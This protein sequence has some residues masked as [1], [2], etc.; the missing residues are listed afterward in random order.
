MINPKLSE[1]QIE[2]GVTQGIGYSLYE[3]YYFDDKG[4]LINDSF[5]DYKLPTSMDAPE[6]I[7]AF[8]ESFEVKGPFGAKGI[9]EPTIVPTA[10]AIANAIYDAIGIRLTQMPF[11]AQKVKEALK[12]I[13]K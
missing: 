7:N 11:T 1:G 4:R 13:K 9:G 8:A 3:D 10:P 12:A 2:G 6:F 5:L